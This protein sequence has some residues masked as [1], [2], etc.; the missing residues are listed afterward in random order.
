MSARAFGTPGGI[1]H[2]RI[3]ALFQYVTQQLVRVFSLSRIDRVSVLKYRAVE[4]ARSA[5]WYPRA[6][7][8]RSHEHRFR[9]VFLR[10]VFHKVL[11]REHGVGYQWWSPLYQHGICAYA[12]CSTIR[13]SSS[14]QHTHDTHPH[15]HTRA[16]PLA[17]SNLLCPALLSA[18]PPPSSRWKN[19][20]VLCH[21]TKIACTD[22]RIFFYF[23]TQ[24]LI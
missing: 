7:R 12:A 8:E 24:D 2:C 17:E 1:W 9:G 16:H 10:I 18:P 19:T 21:I 5:H 3:S 20:A 22:I 4:G 23:K 6:R 13:S 15:T 11:F 14:S